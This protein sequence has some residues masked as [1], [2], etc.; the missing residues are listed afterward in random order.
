MKI[1]RGFQVLGL[2]LMLGLTIVNVEVNADDPDC[3][4][5]TG[6]CPTGREGIR[7]GC[8][9]GPFCVWKE[10]FGAAGNE[11]GEPANYVDSCDGG[12]DCYDCE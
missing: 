1:L 7:E 11:E 8:G 6:S 12:I 5:E 2:A 3:F 4:K 10:C 9:S